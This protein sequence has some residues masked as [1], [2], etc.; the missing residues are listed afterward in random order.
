M[1]F[2]KVLGP[3]IHTLSNI[4]SHN[5]HSS[6]IITAISFVGDGSGLTGVASTDNIVTGSAATFT[7]GVNA[8]T[9]NATS[10]I[11]TGYGIV[12]TNADTN[13]LFYGNSGSDLFYMRD[14]TNSQMITTWSPN[15]FQVNK[16]FYVAGS[17]SFTG[18]ASFASIMVTVIA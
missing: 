17:S 16:A 3:G 8:D 13:Y 5:I 4:T 10:S 7:G 18:A 9:I 11:T 14:T 1:A 15:Y 2:T 12:L 6:G